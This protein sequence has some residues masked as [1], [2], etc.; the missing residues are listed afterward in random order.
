MADRVPLILNNTNSTIQELP[1]GDDLD[2]TS[3]NIKISNI[4]NLRIPGGTSG[5]GII[6]DGAG[7]LSFGS[8][9]STPAGSNTQI[10]FNDANSFGA[11]S[12]LTF[13][14]TDSTLT[15]PNV[16][17]SSSLSVTGTA[18]VTGNVSL[19]GTSVNSNSNISLTGTNVNSNSNISL[20]GS[21]ISLGAIG[22]IKITGGTNNQ[23]IRTDGAGNLSFASVS[24]DSYMLLP[25]RVATSNNITL[26]GLQTIDNVTVSAGDRVLLYGQTSSA[27]NGIYI[28]SSS[29]WTRATD[30]TTGSNTLLGGVTVA[31]RQGTNNGSGIFICTN[32]TAI[33]I[34]T[35]SIT[36]R[37]Q[38]N[39]GIISVWTATEGFN[40]PAT[41]FANSGAMGFGVGA[42]APP[43]ST[44]MGYNASGAGT[45]TVAIGYGAN[46]NTSGVAIGFD[47]KTSA[48][49]NCVSIGYQANAHGTQSIAIGT[50]TRTG[51][52]GRSVAIGFAANAFGSNTIA[53]GAGAYANVGADGVAVGANAKAGSS[54]VNIGL[55]AGSPSPN[56]AYCVSIG[57][58]AG[59][60]GQGG[61][62][63]AIG[64]LAGQTN[65]A[66]NSII[67]NATGS[68][69]N[70]TTANTFTVKPI[71]A[72]TDIT[73]LKQIY[74][75][76]T[77][78]ELVYYNV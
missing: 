38:T 15:V 49:S 30:F 56:G 74:Y 42:N 25:V 62:S 66:S 13:N 40:M 48:G 67:L 26:S 46:A 19:T 60:I 71:R 5:Q 59:S 63:I 16:S 24:G 35:T 75:N 70:Q 37:R 28:A 18:N 53:I 14:K 76:P 44:V 23:L 77:T 61:N 29:T 57:N 36:W 8:V 11:S 43:D 41:G 52:D 45:R 54:G 51:N 55:N 10:Q 72:V 73:G 47:A 69:L 34:G 50:A 27:E 2:V 17:V 4:A 7:N 31:V 33:T 65:Q 9:S 12:N 58:G 3:A 39:T 20:T 68:A 78:G 64:S 21:N 32:A 22:N 1:T 6:T